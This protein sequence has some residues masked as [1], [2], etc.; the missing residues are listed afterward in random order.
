M[1]R[2]KDNRQVPKRYYRPEQ[3]TCP[4][5]GQTLKRCYPLWRKYIVFLD[6]RY[7]VVSM[8]YS[9]QNPKCAGQDRVY[10]SQA[11]RRL[12]VRGSSFA[13]EVIVQ[14]GYWRFWK[15]WTVAQIH[16]LLTQA[17]HLPISEREVLYLI[18][19]FLV[20]L[21]CTYHLRLEEHA[22]YFRRHGVFIA[23][24]ALKPEKGNIALYVVRELTFGLVL[25]QVSLL[26]TAHQTLAARLLQPVKAL[27]YR[28]RG[29]VSDDEK[30]LRLAVA[31]VFP[32]VPHQTCQ[33]HCLRDAALP[34]VEA[35]QAFKK[36]LKQA[37]RS[38]FYAV[39]RAIDELAPDDPCQA[40][41]S[42]YADLIRTTLTEGSKPPFALGGLRVFED[43]ARLDASLQRSRKKGAIRFWINSW[44]SSNV[45]ARSRLSIAVSNV[46][47]IG[48]WNWTGTWIPP[49]GT[50]SHVQPAARSSGTSKTF[51][52]NWSNTPQPPLKMPRWWRISARRSGSAGLGSL[53]A[54]RGPNV[55]A[56]T[57]TSKVSSDASE[58]ASDRF[59]VANPCMSSSSVTAS[60]Q[61]SSTRL[62]PLNRCFSASNS[63]TKPALTKSMHA[64]ARHN[65]DF[66]CNTV[67]ATTRAVV[68]KNWNNNGMRRF[69]VDHANPPCRWNFAVA[70]QKRILALDNREIGHIILAAKQA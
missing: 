19:V 29:L 31:M 25:H 43:L 48:W 50:V 12:T 6:G 15:R 42:T 36:A 59:M 33:V 24:D 14:I 55:G 39:C 41:L 34:I 69:T 64:S 56:P 2:A 30:A 7:L 16:E 13:L 4:R 54:T 51:W 20:L 32:D 46:N 23:I 26:S 40:V 60:G 8:G 1:R 10:E 47:G 45:A 67:F 53:P 49:S 35:D 28:V 17:H 18:E 66:A 9:C 57:T 65:S 3:T 27:G 63:F 61:S 22:T 38:P 62:N 70:V 5:C 58:P 21:R 37:I 44:P 68:S 11:A 52:L